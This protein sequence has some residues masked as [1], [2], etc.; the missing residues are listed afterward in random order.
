MDE[1]NNYISDLFKAAKE[2]GYVCDLWKCK[3]CKDKT[4]VVSLYHPANTP[5]GHKGIYTNESG[6]YY[7]GKDFPDLELVDSYEGEDVSEEKEC[8]SC[9]VDKEVDEEDEE[10]VNDNEETEE[11]EEEDSEESNI[12]VIHKDKSKSHFE[13]PDDDT[14]RMD[15]E[16][17]IENLM[18]YYVNPDMTPEAY[19]ECLNYYIDL[20]ECE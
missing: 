8:K 19:E 9:K 3:S 7:E 10:E 11:D 17:V 15:K 1:G 12:E 18:H 13:I 5:S 14:E 16:E 20:M 2:K 4:Q 6:E